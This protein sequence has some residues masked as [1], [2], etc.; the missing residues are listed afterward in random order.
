MTQQS[1]QHQIVDNYS[2]FLIFF[3]KAYDYSLIFVANK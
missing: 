3:F 2:I 1:Y